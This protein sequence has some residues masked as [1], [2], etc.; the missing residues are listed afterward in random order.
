MKACGDALMTGAGIGLG[1]ALAI[2]IAA[3]ILVRLQP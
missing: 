1:A 2:F 3:A